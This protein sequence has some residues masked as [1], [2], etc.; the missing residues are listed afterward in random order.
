MSPKLKEAIKTGLAFTL[1]YYIAL[2]VA[3][4]NPSWA[5]TTVAMIALPTAGQSIQKGFNRLVGTVPACLVAF[6]I[7]GVAPQSRWLFMALACAW[8]FFTTYMMLRSRSHGYMWNVMGFVCL[9]ILLTGPSSSESLFQHAVF[10]TMETALGIV[11]YTLVTVFLWPQT[12][13]G[14]IRKA[15]GALVATQADLFRAVRDAMAGHDAKQ[16]LQDLHAQEVQQLGQYA[17]AL[18]AEGSESWEVQRVR[19]LLE[20]LHGL[21]TGVMETVDRLQSGIGKLATIDMDA[22]QP[23]LQ[24]YFAELDQ[25]FQEIRGLLDGSPADHEPAAVPL[26]VDADAVRR[27]SQLDRAALAVTRSELE[28][29]DSLTASM[30]R[31]VRG[32]AGEPSGSGAAAPVPSDEGSARA[33][34]LPVVDL[35]HLKAAAFAGMTVAACFLLWIYLNPPGHSSLYQFGGA[36]AMGIAAIPQVRLVILVKPFAVAFTLGLAVYVFI[37][38]QLSSFLGLGVVLFVCMFINRYFFGALV[39]VFTFTYLRQSSRPEKVV[40]TLLRRFF[41][42]AGRLIA[43][44]TPEVEGERTWL[45]RW[46]AEFYRRELRALPGKIGAWGKFIN[47]KHFPDISPEE[48]LGLVTSLQTLVYRLEELREVGDALH[49]GSLVQSMGEELRAW[50]AGVEATFERWSA[51]DET[52]PAAALRERLATWRAGLE[53][54]IGELLQQTDAGTISRRDGERFYRLLGGVRGVSE[55]AVA[56]AGVAG[57]INLSHWRE[58]VFS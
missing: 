47:P 9:V 55:A 20:Q 12:N 19:P 28:K 2:K 13:A 45:Q 14:A 52:E 58:E 8:I 50:S 53:Q 16:R 39:V 33:P 10:R 57:T 23:G 5:V 42:Y 46:K 49:A 4:L 1:T 30:L 7:M 56:Y 18:Q 21:S 54:R 51:S 22:L 27:L 35:D 6:F 48:V 36:V 24:A 32:L 34:W 17:Q 41:R 40:L 29:L 38:P 26:D 31:C 11:V 15:A 44:M 3:W 37:M 43:G 25:R